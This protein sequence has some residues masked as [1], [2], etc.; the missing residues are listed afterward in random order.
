MTR[1]ERRGGE[2]TM[3]NI[4]EGRGLTREGGPRLKSKKTKS[5][6]SVTGFSRVIGS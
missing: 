6:E 4:G 2:T 1:N 3:G 5:Y